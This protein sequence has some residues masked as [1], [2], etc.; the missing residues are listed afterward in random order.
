MVILK[1]HETVLI[2][3]PAVA[4]MSALW[5]AVSDSPP[6]SRHVLL[7]DECLEMAKKA[8]S[9]EYCK[10]FRRYSRESNVFIRS[11]VIS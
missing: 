7:V 4:Q 8:I 1:L 3:W 10:A 9:D 5:K 6:L 2:F 11:Q